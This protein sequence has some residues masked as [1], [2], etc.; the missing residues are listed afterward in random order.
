M[1]LRGKWGNDGEWPW[2][3]QLI[4]ADSQLMGFFFPVLFALPVFDI[5]GAPLG[6]SLAA[7]WMWW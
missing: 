2:S 5:F 3:D 7:D 6:T 1:E 4:W